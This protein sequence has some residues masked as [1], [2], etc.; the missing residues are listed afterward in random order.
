MTFAASSGQNFPSVLQMD[1]MSS[2]SLNKSFAKKELREL[3][4]CDS[5]APGEG[6][7]EELNWD[8]L[9]RPQEQADEV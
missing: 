5:T 6:P 2:L 8:W 1:D 7:L 4:P 9:C 3:L